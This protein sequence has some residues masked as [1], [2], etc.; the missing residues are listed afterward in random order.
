MRLEARCKNGK[1]AVTAGGGVAE[2]S[3]DI[4]RHYD[5]PN[6]TA[7]SSSL[8][9]R[10]LSIASIATSARSI[11][12]LFSS[13]QHTQWPSIGRNTPTTSGCTTPALSSPFSQQSFT[14]SPQSFNSTKRSSST[15]P[16]TSSPSSSVP[17]LK[18]SAML[19]EQSRS[20][21]PPPL[22]VSDSLWLAFAPHH[23]MQ[24]HELTLR[25]ATLHLPSN[26][27]HNRP[28]LRGCRGLPSHLAPL[29]SRPPSFVDTHFPHPRRKVNTH[30]H[31][32]G[33]PDL[34]HPMRRLRHRSL[35]RLDRV[36]C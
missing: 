25:I 16:T 29:P 24:K 13:K 35:Q 19:S 27:H 2:S 3:G 5:R 23:K 18:L 21:I 1:F 28:T 31:H 32:P 33:H 36:D 7:F 26:L 11:Y 12:P 6:I 20:R 22:Y 15:S 8:R 14:S 17:F 10:A 9:T 34:P 4:R 30:L